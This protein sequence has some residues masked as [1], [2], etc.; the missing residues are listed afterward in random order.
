M[1]GILGKKLGMT[2][3]FT[4]QGFRVPVTVVKAGPCVVT[5]VRTQDKN[6]YKAVQLGFEP[7]TVGKDKKMR[8]TRPV[9]GQFDRHKLDPQRH[10]K[11]IRVQ[12]TDE[13]KIGQEIK[14]DIFKEG[15]KVD[16]IGTTIG[17][18]FAGGMKRWNFSG[19]GNTHGSK[20]HRRPCSAGATDAA[21][22]FKGKRS[23]GHLGDSSSVSLNLEIVKVLPERDLIL[24]KG[25]IPGHRDSLVLV[26]ETVKI[27]RKKKAKIKGTAEA[28]VKDRKAKGKKTIKKKI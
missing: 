12:S 14:V 1:R 18:G 13:F 16:V 27:K 15:E 24:V 3:I 19:G 9:K 26:R 6:G 2:S 5:E 22:T 17:K 21:R 25:A 11:E 4:E 8:I 10:L 7:Y 20:V 28:E 23:P